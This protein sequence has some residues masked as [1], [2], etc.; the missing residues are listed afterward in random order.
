M[1]SKGK[2]S[3]GEGLLPGRRDGLGALSGAAAGPS[4]RVL[5]S[6]ESPLPVPYQR[7]VCTSGEPVGEEELPA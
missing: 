2:G 7:P 4:T 1:W 3:M 5:S 6:G